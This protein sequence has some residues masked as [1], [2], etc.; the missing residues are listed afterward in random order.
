MF[1]FLI[2]NNTVELFSPVIGESIKLENVPDPVFAEK[3]L[4]DGLAFIFEG[5]TIYSPCNGEIIMI[6]S[7]KHAIGI[8]SKETEI[9]IHVGLETVEL[10]GNGFELLIS[11]HSK[12]KRGQPILK[13]NRN[14]MDVNH[15][16]LTT[17][18]IITTKNKEFIIN[19]PSKVDLKTK[20]IITS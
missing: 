2:R 12:V 14:L 9:L 5:D 4:G 1:E 11:N 18:M 13:I 17:M 16:D 6:A 10:N 3:M 15:I 20:V 19:E 8:A 7:T